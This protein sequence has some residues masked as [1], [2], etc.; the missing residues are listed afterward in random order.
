[1]IDFLWLRAPLESAP[2]QYPH[3]L[4]QPFARLGV[5]RRRKPVARAGNDER[6]QFRLDADQIENRI[7]TD[8]TPA[9]E[10]R[11]MLRARIW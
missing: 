1:M 11:S 2:G 8:E 10:Q 5:D 6:Q 7:D 4:S 9:A 3:P